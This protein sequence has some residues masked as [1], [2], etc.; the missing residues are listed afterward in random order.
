[1]GN[2]SCLIVFDRDRDLEQKYWWCEYTYKDSEKNFG[3]EVR[4]MDILFE[5]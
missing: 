4:K 2:A 1:M 3:G 5:L